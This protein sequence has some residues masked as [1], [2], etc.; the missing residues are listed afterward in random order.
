MKRISLVIG[1]LLVLGLVGVQPVQAAYPP[2]A[3]TCTVNHTTVAPGGHVTVRGTHWKA[4]TRLGIFFTKV[5]PG[6]R[7]GKTR[8]RL[9]GTFRKQVTIP[10]GAS[11]GRH[12]I[13][14]RGRNTAGKRVRQSTL[15][16]VKKKP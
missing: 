9:N 16:T 7:I 1:S 2:A 3:T 12:K 13:I 11:L 14:C 6:N 15:V 10:A 8:I 5:K 4:K